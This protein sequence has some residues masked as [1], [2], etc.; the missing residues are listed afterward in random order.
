MASSSSRMPDSLGCGISTAIYE[1]DQTPAIACEQLH[2]GIDRY[3]RIGSA[4][5]FLLAPWLRGSRTKTDTK[6]WRR[7][8]RTAPYPRVMEACRERTGVRDDL[9]RVVD[10]NPGPV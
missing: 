9:S 8:A 5:V 1:R 6:V 7:F 2:E 3:L 10:V 4:A